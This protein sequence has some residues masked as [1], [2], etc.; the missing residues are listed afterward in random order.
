MQKE[1]QIKR[2]VNDEEDAYQTCVENPQV[3]QQFASNGSHGPFISMIDDDLPIILLVIL[4]TAAEKMIQLQLSLVV[5][6][7]FF[8]RSLRCWKYVVM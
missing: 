6:L 7:F 5:M 4:S 3:N 8:L 2:S 1:F